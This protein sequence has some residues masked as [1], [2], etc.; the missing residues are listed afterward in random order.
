MKEK[1]QI[2]TEIGDTVLL[3]EKKDSEYYKLKAIVLVTELSEEKEMYLYER[4]K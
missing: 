4:I 2:E 3:D 1:W